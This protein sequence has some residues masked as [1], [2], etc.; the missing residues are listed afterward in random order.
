MIAKE[1]IN[2]V[3]IRW[4][5]VTKVTPKSHK[6]KTGVPA[7]H[8][9]RAAELGEYYKKAMVWLA[10]VYSIVLI[11]VSWT[12]YSSSDFVLGLNRFFFKFTV[13]C[14]TL[15]KI[16]SWMLHYK[17]IA[18]WVSIEILANKNTILDKNHVI[19]KEKQIC[20]SGVQTLDIVSLLP[21]AMR[22]FVCHDVWQY[23]IDIKDI[24]ILCHHFYKERGVANDWLS[25]Q[26]TYGHLCNRIDYFHCNRFKIDITEIQTRTILY[27]PRIDYEPIE[28]T[29]E[30]TNWCYSRATTQ[31]GHL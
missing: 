29:S 14:G 16:I 3:I 15:I 27:F 7:Q 8:A 30:L 6:D 31:V 22:F 18:A 13:V 20:R 23:S 24:I 4:I 26:L 10:V 12:A 9:G 19:W 28:V 2:L 5:L 17:H 1:Y 11:W 25:V 21:T